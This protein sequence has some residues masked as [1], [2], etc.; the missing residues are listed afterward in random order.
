M[1]SF[2]GQAWL[3]GLMSCWRWQT[4]DYFW[5]G[6]TDTFLLLA[7]IHWTHT[8]CQTLNTCPLHMWPYFTSTLI[9][10]EKPLFKWHLL[11][12]N[13]TSFLARILKNTEGMQKPTIQP[14]SVH[15]DSVGWHVAISLYREL[16]PEGGV[17]LSQFV[18][19]LAEKDIMQ[20]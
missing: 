13:H 9:L 19:Q 3:T 18:W 17:H 7:I 2:Q 1:E 4:I 5:V 16:S 12:W 20:G 14:H 8:K 6:E 15:M 11:P 10:Q